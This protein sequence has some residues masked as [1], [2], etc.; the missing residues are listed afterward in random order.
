MGIS[1]RTSRGL[2]SY[3]EQFGRFDFSGFSSEKAMLKT[4]WTP[5]K[6]ESC[7]A[8]L[9]PFSILLYSVKS[10]ETVWSPRDQLD[11]KFVGAWISMRLSLSLW[12]KSSLAVFGN[13]AYFQIYDTSSSQGSPC[14]RFVLEVIQIAENHLSDLIILCFNVFVDCKS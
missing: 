3:G 10:Y 1:R 4:Y 13:L 8:L 9:V 5:Y 6:S 2:L 14:S 11:W 12:T 7:L